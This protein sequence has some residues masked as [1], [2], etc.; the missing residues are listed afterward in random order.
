MDRCIYS[1]CKSIFSIHME[2]QLYTVRSPEEFGY[3][4]LSVSLFYE[5]SLCTPLA[6]GFF[7]IIIPLF[8]HR[9]VC[10][11]EH[12]IFEYCVHVSYSSSIHCAP[13]IYTNFLS[14]TLPSLPPA[15]FVYSSIR[16]L[17]RSYVRPS[18]HLLVRLFALE[19]CDRISRCSISLCVHS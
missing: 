10:F 15:L 13:R 16:L 11:A 9:I 5:M 7:F 18:I 2:R 8:F 1:R 12:N 19:L 4:S 17:G 6:I 3:C 14:L